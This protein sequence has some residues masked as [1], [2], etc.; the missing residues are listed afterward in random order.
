MTIYTSLSTLNPTQENTQRI[1]VK[2]LR[3]WKTKSPYPGLYN[4]KLILVDF[5]VTCLTK[6]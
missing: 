1:Q 2:L 3:R 5:E 4:L 6:F